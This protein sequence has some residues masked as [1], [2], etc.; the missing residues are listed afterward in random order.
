MV[1][2][3]NGLG[4]CADYFIFEPLEESPSYGLAILCLAWLH[5]TVREHVG[6]RFCDRQ[7]FVSENKTTRH[8]RVE[9]CSNNK[10]ERC[11]A[12]VERQSM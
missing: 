12:A 5:A 10:R 1:S 8:W 7:V 2:I 3:A 6:G 4:V 9:L 11:R